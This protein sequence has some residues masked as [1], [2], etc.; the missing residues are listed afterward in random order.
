MNMLKDLS[1][2][3]RP[4]KWIN[5][6]AAIAVMATVFSSGVHA[7]G[8][9][10]AG[11]PDALINDTLT[12]NDNLLPIMFRGVDVPANMPRSKFGVQMYF[13]TGDNPVNPYYDSI[14]DTGATWIRCNVPWK[15][16]EP[17]DTTPENYNWELAQRAVGANRD[18]RYNMVITLEHAPE[19]FSG[20]HDGPP[21]PGQSYDDL[22]E[23]MAALAERYDG[24]GYKDGWKNPVINHF[25][26]YNEPDH[27]Q[28]WGNNGAEYAEMLAVVAP[29]IKAANPNAKILFGGVA[30]D[31]FTDLQP[32]DAFINPGDFVRTFVNDVF[33][34]GG[35]QHIDI[36]N[37]HQYPAFRGQ[38][39]PGGQGMGLI[40]KVN[41]TRSLMGQYGIGDK[42]IMITESGTN[43][44]SVPGVSATEESQS[45]F[46]VEL[47]TQAY[48]ANVEAMMWFTM[49]DGE[50]INN[51]GLENGLVKQPASAGAAPYRKKSHAAY[52]VLVSQLE[53]SQFQRTL[54]A[55]ETGDPLMEVHQFVNLVTGKT[56]YVAWMNPV[57][58]TAQ[59]PLKVSGAQATL[60]DIYGNN[61]GTVADADDGA[62]DGAIT[63]TV[64]GQPVYI[65]IN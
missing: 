61:L 63:V 28:R 30:M 53:S 4:N 55:A 57:D 10:T 39:S 49:F 29:A 40:E 32:G 65:Q 11:T 62:A 1:T 48:A 16:I 19:W 6:A 5:I 9:S 12:T 23:F 20:A 26:L 24:D 42:P 13:D 7:T 58:S 18:G 37:I 31:W 38:W 8:S 21:L 2:V 56:H 36:M 51:S 3:L 33:A 64:G 15:K 27:Q 35:G 50:N 47:F 54:S 44:N 41:A 34:A 43:S 60:T 22:A 52:T 59:V 25:E 17:T 14:V 45:R 46:V